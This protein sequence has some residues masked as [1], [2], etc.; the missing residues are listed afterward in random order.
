M[1]KENTINKNS[2]NFLP[3][4]EKKNLLKNLL[5]HPIAKNRNLTVDNSDIS[6]VLNEINKEPETL[7]FYV[8]AGTCG[9][10]AGAEKTIKSINNYLT[11]N[12]LKGEIIEVGC[13]GLCSAEP[14]VDIKVPGKDRVLF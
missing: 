6:K 1:S 14:M 2:F 10:G 8:G 3:V 12:N 11:T 7:S 4:K 9:L 13:I 5:L